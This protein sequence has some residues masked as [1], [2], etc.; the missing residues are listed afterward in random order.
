MEVFAVIVALL[1]I[2]QA[3]KWFR[4]A[5][6]IQATIPARPDKAFGSC[7]VLVLGG[8]G[9]AIALVGIALA[10]KIVAVAP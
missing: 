10:M 5:G 9:A 8:M 1:F 7:G 2:W 4:S 3:S 6:E